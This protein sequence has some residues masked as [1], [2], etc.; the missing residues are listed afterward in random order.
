VKRGGAET[1]P[2]VVQSKSPPAAAPLHTSVMPLVGCAVARTQWRHAPRTRAQL[3]LMRHQPLTCA[4]APAPHPHNPRLSAFAATRAHARR[5]RRRRLSRPSPSCTHTCHRAARPAAAGHPPRRRPT[6]N[7]APPTLAH[8]AARAHST[9]PPRAAAPRHARACTH[10]A[11]RGR[12]ALSA[13]SERHTALCGTNSAHTRS[14]AAPSPRARALAAALR[15]GAPPGGAIASTHSP[16]ARVRRSTQLPSPTHACRDNSTHARPMLAT[17][18]KAAFPPTSTRPPPPT[19]A[20]SAWRS[21]GAARTRRVRACARA[22]ACRVTPACARHTRPQPAKQP[23]QLRSA[24]RQ[25]Q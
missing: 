12:R 8:T 15:A 2:R 4:S 18:A 7:T 17:I 3:P 23:R 25:Q 24:L 1:H 20:G 21:P 19:R 13:A 11:T 5:P 10:A 22:R 16:L 6:S 9:R 14:T